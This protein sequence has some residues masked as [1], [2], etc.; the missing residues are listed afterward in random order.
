MPGKDSYYDYK[1]LILQLI[2]RIKNISTNKYTNSK[3]CL[4]P[5]EG[6][7]PTIAWF[8][9]WTNRR[10]GLDAIRAYVALN[11]RDLS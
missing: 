4:I 1:L 9:A 10:C 3:G 8:A 7:P 11:R 2:F 6:V 5:R